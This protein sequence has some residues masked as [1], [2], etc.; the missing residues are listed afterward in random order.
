MSLVITY[1]NCVLLIYHNFYLIQDI[2]TKEIIERDTKKGDRITWMTLV[3]EVLI[4]HIT[5][6]TTRRDKFGYCIDVWGIYPLF[7]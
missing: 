1:F 5:P 4:T 3:L 2:L 6:A 7:I